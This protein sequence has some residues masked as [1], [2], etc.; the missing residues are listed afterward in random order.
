LD[1]P[2]E[3]RPAVPTVS[4]DCQNNERGHLCQTSLDAH[5]SVSERIIADTQAL[6]I[7]IRSQIRKHPYNCILSPWEAG[8]PSDKLSDHWARS[9]KE[10]LGMRLSSACPRTPRRDIAVRCRISLP[11]LRGHRTNRTNILSFL[12]IPPCRGACNAGYI[13]RRCMW[14]F[15]HNYW[16]FLPPGHKS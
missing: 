15:D 5:A 14:N 7:G 4:A 8:E 3:D 13:L 10:D 9:T 1:P 12:N 2:E 11:C 16:R 6:L